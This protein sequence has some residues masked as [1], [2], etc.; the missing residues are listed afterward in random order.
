M[1]ERNFP[2]YLTMGLAILLVIQA[3]VNMLVAVGLIPIT[4]Q[5][6]PLISRG[7]T[8]TIINGVYFGMILSVSRYARKNLDGQKIEKLPASEDPQDKEFQSSEGME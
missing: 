1:C 3:M 4:G 6:L 8:S 7:G 2:A 5:P